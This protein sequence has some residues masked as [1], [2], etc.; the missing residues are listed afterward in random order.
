MSYWIIVAFF[1]A[2]KWNKSISFEQH[3]K[4]FLTF[5]CFLLIYYRCKF[6]S[7]VKITWLL[8]FFKQ[9]GVS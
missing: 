2:A 1:C 4:T 9:G 5:L 6:Y 3:L 7:T 8:N